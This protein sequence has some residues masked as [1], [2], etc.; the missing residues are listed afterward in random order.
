MTAAFLDHLTHDT[1]SFERKGERSRFRE[2]MK[3][4]EVR[5]AE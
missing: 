4:K 5:K 3:T 2:S 1:Q